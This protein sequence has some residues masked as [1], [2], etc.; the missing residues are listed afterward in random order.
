MTD[1]QNIKE[2]M[3]YINSIYDDYIND[4]Y[5]RKLYGFDYKDLYELFD[6]DTIIK[7]AGRLMCMFGKHMDDNCEKNYSDVNILFRD[8]VYLDI[9]KLILGFLHSFIKV[10]SRNF[11]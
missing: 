5:G 9:I 10:S 4:L 7:S 3:D 1:E 8:L 6:K 2:C 11:S